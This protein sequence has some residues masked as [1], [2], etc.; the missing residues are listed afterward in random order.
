MHEHRSFIPTRSTAAAA[1]LVTLLTACESGSV[2][3]TDEEVDPDV[4]IED[5][6]RFFREGTFGTED[7]WTEAVELPQGLFEAGFTVLDALSIGLQVDAAVVDPLLVDELVAELGTDLSAASA[8]HLNDP[9]L[10]Q[11][12][13]SDNAFVG[14][15]ADDW[16]DDG[17]VTPSAGETLGLS[18]ALC[19]S[20][21]DGSGF[22]GTA[23][24]SPVL[25]S[26]GLRVDGPGAVDL[27]HGAL[28]AVARN[29]RALYP[30]LPLSL[31]TVGGTP[32][33]RTDA[34]AAATAS[35]MDVD[36]L[37]LDLGAFPIG[38]ADV[39][40]EGVG[41]PVTIPPVF[42]VRPVAPYGVAGEF[43]M[44]VD[45][46]N[47]HVL[48]GMDGTNVIDEA[49]A[50]FLDDIAPGIGVQITNE[51]TEVFT[52]TAVLAPPS[53]YPYADAPLVSEMGTEEFPYGRRIDEY[54]LR[55]MALYLQQLRAPAPP[56][57]DATLIDRGADVY[58][59]AC[60]TCH[61]DPRDSFPLPTVPIDFLWLNYSPTTLLVRG[62]PY[63]NLLDDVLTTYDDRLVVY[64][65]IF[66]P[67]QIPSLPRELA[68]P[69]LVGLHLR[70]ELLHDGSV[71]DL[72]A[73][74]DPARGPAAAHAFYVAPGDA[75]ALIEF[76]TRR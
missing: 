43:T 55:T 75:E 26:I 4:Y 62:F 7:Y 29:S 6:R 25:G 21:V 71:P 57:G 76:L 73:L 59:A 2:P 17:I 32:I 13:L 63:T 41:A 72:D 19:H 44:L 1:L 50:E 47:F 24:G 42:Q 35:E 5:G 45:Y 74:L 11:G 48:T 27:D 46:I 30:Y 34:F 52:D 53:E 69:R 39:S 49:G 64:D 22:D 40:P 15:V 60:A 16:N 31:A 51:T 33:A 20:L 8:P 23:I 68:T 67:A 66:D 37:L 56:V 65:Q 10:F 28:L 14:L 3:N 61:G 70:R 58:W 38:H 18:C 12:L 9:G 54:A 36:D